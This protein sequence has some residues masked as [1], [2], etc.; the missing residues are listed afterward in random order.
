RTTD[1]TAHDAQRIRRVDDCVDRQCPELRARYMNLHARCPSTGYGWSTT[2]RSALP[3]AR[4]T[5]LGGRC[6]AL[7]GTT[8][9]LTRRPSRAR[10]RRAPRSTCE[11][12]PA[13]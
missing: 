2:F 3:G 10:P 13:P 6:P 5:Q 11:Q 9:R 8:L 1:A 7:D 4:C 12:R